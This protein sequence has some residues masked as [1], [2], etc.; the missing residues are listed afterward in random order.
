[1]QGKHGI[2]TTIDTLSTLLSDEGYG[3]ITASKK[4]SKLLRLLDMC[5][6][7]MRSRSKVDVVLIDTYSTQ[8]FWYALIVS[9][10]C[11]VMR[12]NYIPIL[13]GG[14]LPNR[15][16]HNPKLSN[17]I[18]KHAYKLVSPSSF[19]KKRFKTYG[20][21]CVYIPNNLELKNYPF[22]TRTIDEVKLLW[23]RSFSEI[24][25]PKMAVDVV[26]QLQDKG[27]KVEL[28]MVGPE[29]D[30]SLKR[31]K[32][33][34]KSL[35]IKAIFTGG[36]SKQDW[37]ALSKKYN[38]FI[39]TTN[40]DNMPVSVIEAMAL[41]LPIVSTNVGGLS[42]LLGDNDTALLVEKENVPQMVDMIVELKNN[43]KLY[44]KLSK[45]ARY[46]AENFD[47]N[48]IKHQWKSLLTS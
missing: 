38:V 7:V 45:N 1:M 6:H 17:L 13:H 34:A 12:L 31:T 37:I 11:R 15:L 19:L 16:E 33:Y 23:V 18:F 4:Q 36:L 9:Q 14:S 39:N 35:D 42:C 25:N 27:F 24:Y 20:Y 41:G 46:K 21:E 3:I 44:Q 8:N 48:K 40:F 22:T 30:G 29:K 43:Q 5:W 32:S 47:W 28:C 2:P 10:L 26:K